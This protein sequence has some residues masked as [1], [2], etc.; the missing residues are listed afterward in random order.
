MGGL[1]EQ[2]PEA[3]FCF[4]IGHAR[5]VDPTMGIAI[6]MLSRFRSRLRQ[7]HMSEVDPG[8][9]HIPISFAALSAF[10]LVAALIPEDCPV[11]LEAMVPPEEIRREAETACKALAGGHGIKDRSIGGLNRTPSGL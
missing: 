6:G 8:G 11:I 9:R 7:I 2:L 4:D 3:S 1:F 5:Q 10:Q